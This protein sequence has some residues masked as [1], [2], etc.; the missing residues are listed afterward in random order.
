M[1]VSSPGSAGHAERVAV[2]AH[3]VRDPPVPTGPAAATPRCA[4]D[5][6]VDAVKVVGHR[7]QRRPS[8]AL[9]LRMG[10]RPG[11]LD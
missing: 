11:Q 1:S 10:F 8:A 4:E 5:Q 3:D 2:A 7:R 6:D 9:Y